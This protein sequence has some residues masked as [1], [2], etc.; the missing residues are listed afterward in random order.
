MKKILSISL[1]IIILAGNLSV[2]LG[3]HICMGIPVVN[4]LMVGHEH[5]TCGMTYLEERDLGNETTISLDCCQDEYLTLEN[6]DLYKNQ[7]ASFSFNFNYVPAQFI[8]ELDMEIE[9]APSVHF[10]LD[11][12]PPPDVPITIAQQVFLI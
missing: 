2:T 5:M 6:G 3:K 4:E 8:Y 7:V 9:E 11:D 12:P 1:A 10:Q